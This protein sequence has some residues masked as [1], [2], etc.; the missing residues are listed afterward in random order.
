M[1]DVP[2]AEPWKDAR[3]LARES[4]SLPSVTEEENLEEEAPGY[5]LSG[6][7]TGLW[8]KCWGGG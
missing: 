3:V 2:R 7:R 1:T 8:A 6:R 5:S 4:W